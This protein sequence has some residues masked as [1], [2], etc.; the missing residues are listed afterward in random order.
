ML[1]LI[2]ADDGRLLAV[3][4]RQLAIAPGSAMIAA[5]CTLRDQRC[6]RML[7]ICRAR[8]IRTCFSA[9]T[10]RHLLRRRLDAAIFTMAIHYAFHNTAFSMPLPLQSRRILPKAALPQ[11][12]LRSLDAGYRTTDAGADFRC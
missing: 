10:R 11:F 9:I 3:R 1:T 8:L 12:L 5:K 4:A 7:L 2:R 6:E